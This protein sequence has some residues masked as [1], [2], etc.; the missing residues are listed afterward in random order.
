MQQVLV[1]ILIISKVAIMVI[2]IIETEEVLSTTQILR[3]RVKEKGKES[4]F[5]NCVINLDTPLIFY[6]IDLIKLS[7]LLI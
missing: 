1:L 3:T 7:K 2:T 6:I 5:A 4:H